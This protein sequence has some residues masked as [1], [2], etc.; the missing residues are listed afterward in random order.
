MSDLEE[1]LDALDAI[2]ARRDHSYAVVAIE[3]RKGLYAEFW[4]EGASGLVVDLVGDEDLAPKDQLTPTQ[5]GAL[6]ALGWDD[7]TG[8]WRREWPDT[9]GR[10]DRQR[11]AHETLRALSEV[12]GATGAVR[13]EEVGLSDGTPPPP[14]GRSG[15]RVV[16]VLAVVVLAVALAVL[17]GAA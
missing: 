5:R 11:V 15:R 3:G 12:Y 17:V 7:A 9:P 13:V 8:M 6:R 16:A 1:L 14:P 2:H 4:A 10:V